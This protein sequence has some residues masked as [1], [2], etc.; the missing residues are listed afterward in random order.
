VNGHSAQARR[1]SAGPATRNGHINGSSPV[2]MLVPCMNSDGGAP[3][4]VEQ[5]NTRA[6]THARPTARSLVISLHRNRTSASLGPI[7]VAAG[8][9]ATPF[10]RSEPERAKSRYRRV[11]RVT[12]GLCVRC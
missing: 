6:T 5:H 4:A 10:V 12:E 2:Q 7:P 8:P 11:T 3:R 1:A 9:K